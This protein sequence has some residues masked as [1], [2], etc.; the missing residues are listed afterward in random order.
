MGSLSTPKENSDVLR[1]E[2][3]G[4]QDKERGGD[5]VNLA[6]VDASAWPS[7]KVLPPIRSRPSA[8]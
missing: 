7:W 1:L 2:R 4:R 6:E 5:T 3:Q 8:T